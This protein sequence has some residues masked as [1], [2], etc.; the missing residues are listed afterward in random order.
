M[1][2]ALTRRSR[3]VPT[4]DGNKDLPADQQVS[5]AYKTMSVPD[6]MQVQE[7]TGVNILTGTQP[8]SENAFR[9]N[10]TVIC[11]VLEQYASDWKN[12][13]VDGEALTD[14]KAVLAALSMR[15]L[16]MFAE[17]FQFI[18]VASVGTED[19]AKNFAPGSARTSVAPDITAEAVAPTTSESGTVEG[20]I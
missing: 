10:W 18:L 11:A 1:A 9:T 15:Y 17:V 8:E 16:N 3:Y 20:S 4:L 14:T 13:S 7:E 5:V 6:V 12:I 2:L 19:D